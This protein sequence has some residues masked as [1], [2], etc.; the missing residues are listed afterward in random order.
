MSGDGAG[1][2]AGKH[3][4]DGNTMAR[5]STNTV[6]VERFEIRKTR[7]DENFASLKVNLGRSG[8]FGRIDAKIWQFDKF[9][10]AGVAPPDE[11][12]V[13]EAHYE[14]DEFRGM[15]QWKISDYRVLE[16]EERERALGEFTPAARIDAEFYNAR[17]DELIEEADPKRVSGQALRNIFA[18]DGFRKAFCHAPAAA[19][20]HQNYPGGLLEHT[21]NVT[22]VAL[23][24]G[25]IYAESDTPSLSFNRET[26]HVD[27]TLLISAGLLH[28]IGKIE[29]YRFSPLPTT[30]DR[31][32]FEGH[33]PLS[34]AIVRQEAVELMEK[35]DYAGV[36]DEVD[37]LINCILSHH[38]IMEYG[39]PVLPACVEA[40]LLSQADIADARLASIVS[41]GNQ[42]LR[43]DATG[44]WLR[45]PHFPGGMF[46]GDWPPPGPRE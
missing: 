21:I 31:H 34:Y 44:R 27:R 2:D 36:Q 1:G 18:R 10:R 8:S 25:A 20:H 29:T 6:M 30:T 38:G 40:F 17:L 24:L 42:R 22:T 41:E 32:I 4:T 7:N 14:T 12:A 15:P 16:G 9:A 35:A 28:D 26:L 11:G 37:K 23:T 39:S 5:T 33:L 13:I 45:H 3:L 46:I 43:Q 19:Q